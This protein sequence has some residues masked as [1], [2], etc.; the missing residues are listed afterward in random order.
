[1][2]DAEDLKLIGIC[3]YSISNITMFFVKDIDTLCVTIVDRR[4]GD[5]A[6]ESISSD[7]SRL[8]NSMY[9]KQLRSGQTA[10]FSRFSFELPNYIQ[11]IPEMIANSIAEKL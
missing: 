5:I 6:G 2:S 1:M 4:L 8:F 10:R 11:T 3:S 9:G 7:V